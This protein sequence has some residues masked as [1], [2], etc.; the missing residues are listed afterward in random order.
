MSDTL[1]SMTTTGTLNLNNK[2]AGA[3]PVSFGYYP[4]EGSRAI[5]LQYNWQQQDQYVEDLSQLVAMGVETSIQGMFIDN[6]TNQYPVVIQ[7]QGTGQVVLCPPSSQGFAPLLFT[8]TPMMQLQCPAP[9]NGVTRLT[10]LNVPT[11]SGF[12]TA[13]LT[14]AVALGPQF[15]SA[16]I[17]ASTLVRLGPGRVFKAIVLATT[18]TGVIELDDANTLASAAPLLIIPTGAAVGTIYTID[19]PVVN[20]IAVNFNSGATGNIILTYA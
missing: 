1:L 6:S 17:G 19:A 10:L 12:W 9:S 2:G 15:V 16:P 3:F 4:E 13:S 18:A 7:V 20:G 5:T 11:P 8:G 14:P